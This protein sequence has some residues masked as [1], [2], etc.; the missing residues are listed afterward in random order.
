MGHPNALD[1]Q[2]NGVDPNGIYDISPHKQGAAAAPV[3][4]IYNQYV[5][6]SK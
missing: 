4:S 5:N 6:N 2:P 1:Q 3:G